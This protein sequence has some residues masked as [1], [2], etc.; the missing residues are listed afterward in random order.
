M[1]LTGKRQ[2]DKPFLDIA[3]GWSSSVTS[4]GCFACPVVAEN[5]DF[6]ISRR[7]ARPISSRTNNSGCTIDLQWTP[8]VFPEPGLSGLKGVKDMLFESQVWL[9]PGDI[10]MTLLMEARSMGLSEA[11]QQQH[12]RTAWAQIAQSPY[13]SPTIRSFVLSYIRIAAAKAPEARTPAETKLLEAF[14]EYIRARRKF[15]AQQALSM[16]DAWK[17]WSDQNRQSRRRTLLEDGFYYGTVPLDFNKTLAS[18]LALN[19]QAL[20]LMGQIYFVHAYASSIE[21]VKTVDEG[22]T[23]WK[24]RPEGQ[25]YHLT[26]GFNILRGS[27]AANVT[28]GGATIINAAFAIL[29]SIAIDQFI[30]IKTARPKLEAAL[31]AAD[32]PVSLTEVLNPNGEDIALLYWSKAMDIDEKED[33]QI[34]QLAKAAYM[35]AQAAGFKP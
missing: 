29:S 31:A 33:G 21:W 32:R 15:L 19:S 2:P 20:R 1:G 24:F 3:G 22:V 17:Q 28:L 14:E 4:G 23:I 27:A 35:K 30:A 9:R 7:N 13:S 6:L 18:L 5:G 26:R 10:T 34:L 11:D 8:P 25:L 16:Y 12:I